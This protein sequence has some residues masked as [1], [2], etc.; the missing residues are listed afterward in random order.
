[1]CPASVTQHEVFEVHP[2][3][4]MCQYFSFIFRMVYS[5]PFLCGVFL[6]KSDITVSYRGLRRVGQLQSVS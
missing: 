5:C 6:G 4:S 2:C 3:S 1:M